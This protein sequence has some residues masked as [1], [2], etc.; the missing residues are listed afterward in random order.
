[1]TKLEREITVAAEPEEVWRALTDEALL[2][3]WLAPEVELEPEEGGELHIVTADG[4]ERWGTVDRVEEGRRLAFTWGDSEVELTVD[5]VSAGRTRVTVVETATR[6]V[7]DWGPRLT[8][9]SGACSL[10]LP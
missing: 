1:M 2:R 9:L 4:E 6:P 3:E 5:A 7:G 10:A 8:A